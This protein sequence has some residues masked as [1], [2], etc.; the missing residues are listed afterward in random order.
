[1]SCLGSHVCGGKYNCF[2][3]ANA[4]TTRDLWFRIHRDITKQF[5]SISG[6]I[7]R[8][9]ED[10]RRILDVLAPNWRQEQD[11]QQSVIANTHRVPIRLAMRFRDASADPPGPSIDDI[12]LQQL[13]DTFAVQFIRAQVSL[14]VKYIQLMKCAWILDQMRASNEFKNGDNDSHWPS[15]VRNLEYVSSNCPL[16]YYINLLMSKPDYLKQLDEELSIIGPVDVTSVME[17]LQDMS[18]DIFSIWPRR[19]KTRVV[20]QVIKTTEFER[21]KK[22]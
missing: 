8:V 20:N 18:P 16:G 3:P 15:L 13:Y 7:G 1:M 6:Q 21:I 12:P 5:R 14:P 9:H 11:T 10:V 4:V 17:S 19:Q 2:L 22:L